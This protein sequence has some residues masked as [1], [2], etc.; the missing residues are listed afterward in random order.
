MTERIYF[1]HNAT[2][3]L[4]PSARAAMALALD[5]P[6]NASSI[7]AEGRAARA[8]IERA[9]DVIAAGLGTRARNV[10]FTSGGTEAA[11]LALTPHFLG[12]DKQPLDALLMSAGEHPCVLAGRRFDD[13]QSET[14]ALG[15][16]GQIDLDSLA[17][18]LARR[19]GQKI[20][21][22]LQAANNE[23]GVLQPV[24][25]AAA[26]VHAAGGVLVCDAVQGAGRIACAFSQT[27]ADMLLLSA[28][29]FGGPKGA[30]ALV[31]ADDSRNLASPLLLGGGQERGSR[32]G[33]ENIAAIAGFAEAFIEA[34]AS[35]QR[36]SARL[37]ALRDKIEDEMRKAVPALAVFGAGAPRLANTSAFAI[38][39][40]SAETLLIAFDLDGVALSSGSA[41]S[42]GKVKASHVLSAMGVA[43]DLIKGALRLSLGWTTKDE[44][45]VRFVECFA[46]VAARLAKRRDEIP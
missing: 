18:A 25:A 15:A 6:G 12:G 11:N 45:A 3:P 44:D 41:C 14:V 24:A 37:G 22:A 20:M 29:K 35:R 27:G 33:T 42:S 26:M 16:K 7:H 17:A 39:G 31:L 32:A 46:K 34:E 9:R 38:P 13:E 43:P 21:L 28:H 5:L 36:E 2:S 8:R 19:K 1:D 30:G 4:R 10:I 40:L 23:T